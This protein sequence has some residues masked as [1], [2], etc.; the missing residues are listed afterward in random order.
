MFGPTAI[1]RASVGRVRLFMPK[2][3]IASCNGGAG[4]YDGSGVGRGAST[5]IP[6]SAHSARTR[7]MRSSLETV[8]APTSASSQRVQR[9]VR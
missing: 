1:R 5:E 6:A 4:K 7:A 2:T 9:G 8:L 3:P